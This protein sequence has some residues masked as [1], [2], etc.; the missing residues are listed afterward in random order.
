VYLVTGA[1]SGLGAAVARHLTGEGAAVYAVGT[2]SEGVADAVARGVAAAGSACDVTNAAATERAVA[3]AE[4]QLGPLDGAFVNAGIDGDGLPAVDADPEHFLRVLDVNVRG[5]FLTA[6]TVARRLLARAGD[7][8]AGAIVI[9]ASVNGIRPEANFASYN[10]SKAA[11]ISLAKTFALE[12]APRVA[13]TA[14]APGYFPS[15]MTQPYLDDPEIAR[16]LRALIPAGRFGD[17][18]ELGA[19]VSLLLSPEG[20]F[21]TGGCITIDGGRSV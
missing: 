16:E 18:G 11:A 9:N 17:P 20:A 6:R 7:G 13:V 2:T 3:D 19:L 15:R 14:V 1:T 21:L 12:W 8:P 10:A 5:A 4:A